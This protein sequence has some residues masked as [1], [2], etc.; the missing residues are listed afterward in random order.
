MPEQDSSLAAMIGA[1][2][3]GS[4]AADPDRA[5]LRLRLVRAAQDKGLTWQQIG[6]VL[7][8]PSGR[9]AKHD[10]HRL[11]VKTPGGKLILSR[12]NG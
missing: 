4:P 8:Y 2:A 12:R 3:E 10:I 11:A 9:Q 7:G 6:A 1:I 5:L